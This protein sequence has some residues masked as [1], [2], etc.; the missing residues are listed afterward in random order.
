M[1]FSG[2]SFCGVCF[3]AGVVV[4]CVEGLENLLC[5]MQFVLRISTHL[6]LRLMF[7][8]GILTNITVYTANV[9]LPQNQ[10]KPSRPW[11][12]LQLL[13]KKYSKNNKTKN[14][15]GKKWP[16]LT[17]KASTKLKEQS[18]ETAEM[19][20]NKSCKHTAQE[21][22]ETELHILNLSNTEYI[23]ALIF[24]C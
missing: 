3:W 14:S 8:L 11:P 21:P 20:G 7:Q 6:S 24:L 10:W 23:R 17:T 19:W 4:R 13:L 9:C 2:W 18:L 15:H 12:T 16:M 1:G 22:E 5:L